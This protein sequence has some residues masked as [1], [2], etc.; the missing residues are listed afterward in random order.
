[1]L[2]RRAPHQARPNGRTAMRVYRASSRK[3]TAKYFGRSSLKGSAAS[4]GCHQN[5]C[6]VGQ[7]YATTD[8]IT[9]SSLVKIPDKRETL[10]ISEDCMTV[11]LF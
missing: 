3:T 8:S 6:R 5:D 11:L 1:M 2:W 10:F 7:S 4:V 9:G